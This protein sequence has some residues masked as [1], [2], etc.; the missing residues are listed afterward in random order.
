[1]APPIIRPMLA[2]PADL[3]TLRF[4]LLASAKLD[5]VRAIVR[6]G[7]VLSR[8]GKPI[9]NQHIQTLF[10]DFEGFDG[11]LVV[12]E[13]TSPTCYRTTVSGV[14]AKG[15]RPNAKFYVF[16]CITDMALPYTRRLGSVC[17]VHLLE[18][19]KL[20]AHK[21][22]QHVQHTCYN[23]EDVLAYEERMLDAGYEGL[24]LRSPDA[25]YKRGRSTVREQY[26]LKL[27]R[28]SDF[29]CKVIGFEER[30]HNSNEAFTNE[31]GYTARTSHQE[32]KIGRGDLGALVCITPEGVEFRVG[33][34]FDDADRS[35][36]WQNRWA[37][38]EH[39]AKIK[40][41][42]VGM[43][44]APRHPVFLGWRNLEDM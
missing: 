27:K 13:P 41:F 38:M 12:G 39:Y 4:P 3:N 20:N 10:K 36:I 15:G 11:E 26:L 31:L 33:T 24:I 43:K 19:N 21:V 17:A 29:E 35:H 28:F 16:D 9:P 22:V 6:N 8:S 32:G 40:Y 23:L 37:Y 1:M 5:G 44:D 2:S 30:M 14:M 7:T 42:A 34:G 25:P 18:N